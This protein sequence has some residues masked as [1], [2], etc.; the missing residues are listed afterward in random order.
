MNKVMD[1]PRLRRLLLS[2]PVSRVKINCSATS[3]HMAMLATCSMRANSSMNIS[4]CQCS[5]EVRLCL[6]P[7]VFNSSFMGLL[8]GCFRLCTEHRRAVVACHVHFGRR[9][10]G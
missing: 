8:L 1:L 4:R 2:L 10:D 5:G 9:R 7:L 3:T 6:I